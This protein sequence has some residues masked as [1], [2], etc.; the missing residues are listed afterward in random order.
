MNSNYTNIKFLDTYSLAALNMFC[1][2]SSADCFFRGGPRTCWPLQGGTIGIR[3][4]I[5]SSQTHPSSPVYKH[6]LTPCGLVTISR[7]RSGSTWAQVMIACCLTAP[8]NYQKQ[9]QLIRNEAHWHLVEGNFT[10]TSLDIT[11]THSLENVVWK[12]VVILSRPQ[13]VTFA[14]VSI[15]S[16]WASSIECL[17]LLL[18]RVL[19]AMH[20]WYRGK[21]GKEKNIADETKWPPWF[22]HTTF[23][24]FHNWLIR[25][26]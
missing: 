11:C 12:M 21:P 4:C 1:T 5:Y 14:V 23:A 6:G 3:Q 19:F 20:V 17:A 7:H 13:W 18:R 22:L 10:E 8:S 15:P 24:S 2:K 9:S 25:V 26:F 16:F